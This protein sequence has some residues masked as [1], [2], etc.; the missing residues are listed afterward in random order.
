MISQAE[1]AAASYP[2][3]WIAN[4]PRTL[5]NPISL[6]TLDVE[7]ND[8]PPLLGAVTSPCDPYHAYLG[9]LGHQVGEIASVDAPAFGIKNSSGVHNRFFSCTAQFREFARVQLWDRRRAQGCFWFRISDHLQWHHSFQ[10]TFKIPPSQWTD[11][12]CS[13]DLTP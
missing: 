8:D 9:D 1:L 2:A 10:V 11:T 12:S 3:L 7:G 4:Q 6:P 5:D 13:A